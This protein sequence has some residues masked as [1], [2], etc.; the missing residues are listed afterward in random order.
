M[1][2]YL[3][4]RCLL[5]MAALSATLGSTQAWAQSPFDPENFSSTF[6][7]TTDYIFRGVSFSG[8]E[9]AIQGSFD[10]SHNGWFAGV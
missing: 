2:S 4:N 5:A 9:P 1:K 8:E 3:F 7:I 6:T 10:W